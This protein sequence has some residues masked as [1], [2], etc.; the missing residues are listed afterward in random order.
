MNEKLRD[1]RVFAAISW[2]LCYH[3]QNRRSHNIE[4]VLLEQT[5]A[6]SQ[7]ASLVDESFD[8]LIEKL[9]KGV[10]MFSESVGIEKGKKVEGK[11]S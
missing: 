9:V 1:F 2:H 11:Q 3:Q 10:S 7:T 6:S 5:L 8:I 4:Y